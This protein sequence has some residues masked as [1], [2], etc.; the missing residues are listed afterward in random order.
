MGVTL[1]RAHCVEQFD[2]AVLRLSQLSMTCKPILV[3]VTD[4]SFS[5]ELGTNNHG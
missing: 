5:R 1:K 2:T 4:Q 3:C